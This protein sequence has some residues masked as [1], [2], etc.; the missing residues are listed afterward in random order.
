[1]A[2]RSYS[3]G[4]SRRSA[5]AGVLALILGAAPGAVVNAQDD[6]LFEFLPRGTADL[7]PIQLEDLKAIA[8]TPE[9]V[10]SD[11]VALN[12]DVLEAQEEFILNLP[13][14]EELTMDPA[15]FAIDP[16]LASILS[17][18]DSDNLTTLLITPDGGPIVGT[19]LSL[20]RIY[21][22]RKIDGNQLVLE[23]NE[24]AFEADHP[25]EFESEVVEGAESALV[26][27]D[28]SAADVADVVPEID[29]L[30]G[31]TEAVR[32]EAETEKLGSMDNVINRLLVL[33]NYTFSGN[34]IDISVRSVGAVEV[35]YRQ[36]DHIREEAIDL[37]MP[38]PVNGGAQTIHPDLQV[39]H[40]I[41]D[42]RGADVV[43]L[44][45]TT[46]YPKECGWAGQIGATKSTALAVVNQK[47]A[48][49][50]LSLVHELGHLL[51]GRHQAERDGA[52][53]PAAY[54]HGWVSG[55]GSRRTIMATT[56]P[57]GSKAIPGCSRRPLWSSPLTA[58]LGE[59]V[60]SEEL[61]NTAR[62]LTETA[63]QVASFRDPP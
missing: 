14:R 17:A 13:R 27:I 59:P 21:N 6:E 58:I 32:D 20:D 35:P 56:C 61:A 48:L 34:F 44:L 63:G 33:T 38:V 42:E 9:H 46:G 30:F 53:E 8:F 39:L 60:G 36:S 1:M 18:T 25:P 49:Y 43:I 40:D 29:V 50:N 28:T 10:A 3:P 11:L 15:E 2:V 51:G 41:A 4:G 37:G 5:C 54:G 24:Y 45:T 7:S 31:Y 23:E 55:D 22:V 26:A 19:I 57:T 16:N 52:V 12:P 47:C 62:L